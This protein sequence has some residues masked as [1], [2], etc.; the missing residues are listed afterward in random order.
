M[1]L[2]WKL[3]AEAPPPPTPLLMIHSRTALP[4]CRL[5]PA[6]R[7]APL[8]SPLR[9]G[10]FA[11]SSPDLPE[12][13]C[14]SLRRRRTPPFFLQIR[15]ASRIFLSVLQRFNKRSGVTLF[16]RRKWLVDRIPFGS[17]AVRLDDG[18]V[19]RYSNRTTQ[20]CHR[21]TFLAANAR[22]SNPRPRATA[23]VCRPQWP[24]EYDTYLQFC[25]PVF[26]TL[27]CRI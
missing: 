13:P 3:L 9:L 14:P 15:S 21:H 2:P 7:L 25:L 8:Y 5:H 20:L 6:L 23:S 27:H 26:L 17:V 11:I 10:R 19:P 22:P 4:C 16:G 18:H 24:R 1:N 12:T